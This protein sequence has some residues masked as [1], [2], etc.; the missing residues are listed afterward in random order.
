MLH[1]DLYTCRR[2]PF[3]TTF[4]H[5]LAKSDY[6]LHLLYNGIDF[7]C[8]PW[9]QNQSDVYRMDRKSSGSVMKLLQ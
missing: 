2:G 4:Q 8:K 7:A 5:S 1:M 6:S 9:G 3:V